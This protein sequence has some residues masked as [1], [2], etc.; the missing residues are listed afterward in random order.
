MEL[1]KPVHTLSYKDGVYTV[2]LFREMTVVYELEGYFLLAV[3]ESSASY[4]REKVLGPAYDGMIYMFYKAAPN[5]DYLWLSKE[6][7]DTLLPLWD[8][9]QTP[10]ED[11]DSEDL[12]EE[13][14]YCHGPIGRCGG[15]CK[16]RD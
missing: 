14:D 6:E 2:T 16:D 9:L 5:P 12:D 13:C 15:R 8:S 1:Q 10:Y 7:H 11:D 4:Y 3:P